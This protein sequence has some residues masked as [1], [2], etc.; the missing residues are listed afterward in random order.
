MNNNDIATVFEHIADLLEIKGEI[1]YKSLAYRRAAESIRLQT[2]EV[3]SL[4]REKLMEIP[5]IGQAIADKIKELQLSGKLKFLQELEKEVP[6]SL[7]D[8][9]MVPDL[10]PKKVALFWKQLGITTLEELEQAARANKLSNLPGM[11]EKSQ[12]HILA[13]I[14]RLRQ[15]KR[16]LSIHK[17]LPIAE[18][19]LVKVK[20]ISNLQKL[21]VAGSLR[22]WKTNI[23]DLDFVGASE[24]PAEA[25]K[26]FL[27]LEGIHHVLSQGEHKTSVVTEDGLNLQLWLQPSERFGSLLQ[28][29]TG[30]KEHNVRLREFAIK[31]GLSL[32]ERGFLDKD[33][34]EILCTKEEDVYQI[35]G[36]QFIPPELREDRGEIDAAAEMNLPELVSMKDMRAD[37]HIHTDWTDARSTMEEMIQSA[38]QLGLQVIAITD[39]SIATTRVNGLDAKRWKEQR[40]FV[41]KLREK[42]AK[43]IMILHGLETEILEDGSLDTS[44][45]VLAQM[46]IVLVSMHEYID[47]PRDVITTRLVKAMKNPHVDIVA[48]PS[49]RELPRTEGANLDWE[50]I[51]ATAHE[52]HVALEIDCNPVH[53]DLDEVHARQAVER[54]VLISI[55][56]DSHT[57]QKLDN[58]KY[59]VAIARRA[60]V[61]KSSV[62]NTWPTQ[63]LLDWLKNRK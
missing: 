57:A 54:G 12:A 22:R 36:L 63:K 5:G 40:D 45:D 29:V 43:S 18:K 59:G 34:K 60:W 52:Y 32:S 31:K 41:K 28:F 7:V 42:Y 20:G 61:E 1:I 55:D 24:K 62:L 49:G 13:G 25:M 11:G 35:L 16:R 50:K 33:L 44:D 15:Q 17:A 27:S 51:Y 19:W 9:L 8:L 26:E 14:E 2:E 30:S 47:Q 53:F 38:I 39:H 10:G 58:L 56:T 21:E 48:H 6:P 4:S 46:D 23:G 37:L 3:T